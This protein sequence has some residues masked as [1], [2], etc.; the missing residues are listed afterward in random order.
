MNITCFFFPLFCYMMQHGG[1]EIKIKLVYKIS[2]VEKDDRYNLIIFET[3]L[4]FPKE[5][6]N[7][8][9]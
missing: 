8:E 6:K 9:K 4:W 7:R 1:I 5:N 2:C 3:F